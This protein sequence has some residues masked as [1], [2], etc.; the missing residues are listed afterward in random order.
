MY[1]NLLAIHSIFRWLVLVSLIYTIIRAYRGWIGRK[2][3]SRFDN[4]LRHYTATIAHI[5]F[6]LGIILY[7]ISPLVTYF[8]AE[9]SSAVHQRQIR[10]FSMEHSTMMLL[11]VVL[12]TIG[13]MKAKRKITDLQKFKTVAI[14]YSVSLLIILVNIPWPFSPFA[15]RP[16]FREFVF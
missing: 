9:F 5:Q 6:L 8:M 13:S 10:F 1:P 7:F 11:S 4:R 2:I 12:I 16:Y 15:D 3:F 14:W